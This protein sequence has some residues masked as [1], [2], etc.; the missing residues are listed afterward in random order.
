MSTGELN[1][2]FLNAKSHKERVVFAE[3]LLKDFSDNTV[4]KS[5]KDIP[6]LKNRIQPGVREIADKGKN[7]IFKLP[8]GA[9]AVGKVLQGASD[10]FWNGNFGQIEEVTPV[11]KAT[12]IT[13]AQSDAPNYQPAS[14]PQRCANCR[15]FLGDPGRDWCDLFDF[16]ADPDYV[17]DAWE[18]QRPNEIP[19]YNGVSRKGDI[20]RIEVISEGGSSPLEL[21]NWEN[22]TPAQ[23]K[24]RDAINNAIKAGTL[25][26]ASTKICFRCGKRRGAEYHHIN[27]YHE[28]K[29]LQV[30][31]IC[32]KCH[33]TI[34]QKSDLAALTERVLALRSPTKLT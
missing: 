27:G 24:A 26:K 14:T 21:K 10:K 34:T 32:M 7:A 2:G 18:A 1:L 3:A 28:G 8:G 16:T 13:K 19:E 15:F 29:K 6:K 5:K 9:M 20:T 17:S 25:K 22:S 33:A 31:A 11:F 23:R 4:A 12:L 30:R